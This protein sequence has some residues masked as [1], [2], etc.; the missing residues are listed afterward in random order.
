MLSCTY[1]VTDSD[2]QLSCI[3]L[4]EQTPDLI[5]VI[6]LNCNSD[7]VCV[8][9]LHH[10]GRFWYR[11]SVEFRSHTTHVIILQMFSSARFELDWVL[12]K[13]LALG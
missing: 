10:V 4:V 6:P 11:G 8:H 5:L 2:S 12:T 13:T 9:V 3:I 7:L 1:R